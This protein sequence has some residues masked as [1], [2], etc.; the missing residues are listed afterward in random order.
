MIRIETT[1]KIRSIQKELLEKMAQTPQML[2]KI[3]E[4]IAKI[5]DDAYTYKAEE[6]VIGIIGKEPIAMYAL[7][8]LLQL[9]ELKW[10]VSV[11]ILEKSPS[12][13]QLLARYPNVN[14]KISYME[15]DEGYQQLSMLLHQHPIWIDSI[16]EISASIPASPT[17]QTLIEH[18]MQ[19]K[20][21]SPA[22][23][24]IVSIDTPAGVDNQCGEVNPISIKAEMT[25]AIGAVKIGLMRYP[26]LTRVGEIH[27]AE[28]DSSISVPETS[29]HLYVS[30][31]QRWVV[32]VLTNR[33]ASQE[34]FNRKLT[35]LDGS[36]TSPS[37]L[38]ASALAA[39]SLGAVNVE[40]AIPSTIYE[41][42]AAH[43]FDV[44]WLLLPHEMGVI[45]E[46]AVPIL[47]QSLKEKTVLL[48]GV[49]L[50]LN[51]ITRKFIMRFFNNNTSS[52]RIIGLIPRNEQTKLEDKP[53][54][55]PIIV[56]GN[57]L[58]ALMEN[59]KEWLSLLSVDAI[60][61]FTL[62]DWMDIVSSQEDGTEKIS[63]RII[64]V[65]K[66]AQQ[67]QRTIILI[68]LPITIASPNQ[69]T[70]IIP[71]RV[72]SVKNP[73]MS[74]ILSGL[75]AALLQQGLTPYE[76]SATAA[77]LFSRAADNARDKKGELF[78]IQPSDVIKAL[79]DV[80]RHLQ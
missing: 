42:S 15:E 71:T 67:W 23:S 41:S 31:N 40:L 14:I 61:V 78:N 46:D 77:W 79:P 18:I 34:A 54:Y 39:L 56:G 2:D 26:A 8:G 4:K 62:S 65:E 36:I 10:S 24:H 28:F 6:G 75:T 60:I 49:G 21:K 19:V 44:D 52:S 29:E 5:I 7:L 3:G 63:D 74:A 45:S 37:A 59:N 69:N 17:L 43:I 16:A 51:D 73:K 38:Q 25:I 57:I 50:E 70:V 72:L 32:S 11:Y 33:L 53:T 48:F 13:S 1:S 80:L 35:I 30:P 47:Y 68:D 27:I 64:L 22:L 76:A 20:E 12:L 55:S 58:H 66:Y 9:T